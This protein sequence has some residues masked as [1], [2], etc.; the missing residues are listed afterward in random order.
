MEN[1]TREVSFAKSI[2]MGTSFDKV[3]NL[4]NNAKI[5]FNP[6]LASS[7]NNVYVLWT[8]GTFVKDEFPILT[9]TMFK[10]S[11]NSGQTFHDTTSLNNYTGWSVSPMIKIKDDKLYIL[12]EEISQNRY[13]DIY[14][15]V[16]NIKDAKE[17][18]YKINVSN[19]SNNS[20]NPSIDISNNN[21]HVAWVNEDSN[22]SS[23][24]IIKKIHQPIE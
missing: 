2:D 20:F 11:N 10:Y 17:C 8:N 24:I 1:E 13:S 14:L 15:C 3:T 19:D 9:D 23:S 7:G 16:I 18:N 6:Q 5:S 22:Y 4:T 12:W 21:A